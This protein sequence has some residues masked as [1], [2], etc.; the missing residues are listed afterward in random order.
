MAINPYLNNQYMTF[1]NYGNP[2][3]IQPQQPVQQTQQ[4]GP[5]RSLMTTRSEYEAQNYPIAPG[6]S[7]L[8]QDET[9]PNIFYEK[10]MGF[11]SLDKPTFKRF[12]LVEEEAEPMQK[13]PVQ[14]NVAYATKTEYEELRGAYS[15]LKDDIDIIRKSI[16]LFAGKDVSNEHK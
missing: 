4:Q 9:Q 16:T 10:T 11:S 1:P 6:N 2:Q 13:A 15:K 5:A 12:R 3:W 14:D 7:I 8:F